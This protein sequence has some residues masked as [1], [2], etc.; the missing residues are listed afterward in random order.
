VTGTRKAFLNDPSQKRYTSSY[1]AQ[2]GRDCVMHVTIQLQ[3]L[4]VHFNMEQWIEFG[5]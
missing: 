1:L 3:G 2:S 4:D 5:G